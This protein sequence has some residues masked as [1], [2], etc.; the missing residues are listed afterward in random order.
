MKSIL[1]TNCI[2][3]EMT[4]ILYFDCCI[5][6]VSAVDSGMRAWMVQVP[7]CCN[8]CYR[9]RYSPGYN[10]WGGAQLVGE[11]RTRCVSGVVADT[12]APQS[13][14]NRRIHRWST[15]KEDEAHPSSYT[16]P[17]RSEAVCVGLLDSNIAADRASI[18]SFQFSKIISRR[19]KKTSRSL[20]L[21]Y[22]AGLTEVSSFKK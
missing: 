2:S 3:A 21:N 7:H 11:A 17:S 15:K 4:Y 12:A 16:H 22:W 8:W 6:F 9:Q 19:K 20:T 1:L 14:A 13:R 18:S 10:R 5:M